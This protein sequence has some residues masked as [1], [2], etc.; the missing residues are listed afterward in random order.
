M[1]RKPC[2][3]SPRTLRHP[4]KRQMSRRRLGKGRTKLDRLGTTAHNTIGR[5]GSGINRLVEM[6]NDDV[7]LQK[8]H[9]NSIYGMKQND[10]AKTVMSSEPLHHATLSLSSWKYLATGS[11]L[12][13]GRIDGGHRKPYSRSAMTQSHS[14]IHSPSYAGCKSDIPS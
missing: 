4:T 5:S 12:C 14:K 10:S 6:L 7:W 8:Q 13:P 9:M 2:P 1:E 11:S 3:T